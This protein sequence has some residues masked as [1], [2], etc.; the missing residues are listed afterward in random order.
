MDNKDF[1]AKGGSAPGGKGKLDKARPIK[2]DLLQVPLNQA[3]VIAVTEE[4]V[5]QVK[6]PFRAPRR[7]QKRQEQIG[8]AS[9]R[10]RVY[11]LV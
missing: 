4:V 6:K 2:S 8:R 5:E 11:V 3:A 9:C 10:E 1:P 7:P